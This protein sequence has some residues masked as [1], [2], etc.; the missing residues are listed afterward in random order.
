MW[1]NGLSNGKPSGMHAIRHDNLQ[2]LVFS[3]CRTG[4][5]IPAKL[6]SFCFKKQLKKYRMK[7]AKHLASAQFTKPAGQV[8][9]T[10]SGTD[11]TVPV[12]LVL[13]VS[14]YLLGWQC[15]CVYWNIE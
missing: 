6:Q 15:R 2:G 8:P 13:Q 11:S 12:P 10:S 3:T 7:K 5:P 1:I 14:H 4:T 9:G